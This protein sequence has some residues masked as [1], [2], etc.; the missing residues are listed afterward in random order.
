MNN[1]FIAF[2]KMHPPPQQNFTRQILP[3]LLR[4][5]M[6]YYSK[7]ILT[8][9][10]LAA[11]ATPVNA[12]A[13]K[14]TPAEDLVVAMTTLSGFAPDITDTLKLDMVLQVTQEDGSALGE[15]VFY[16]APDGT[17]TAMTIGADNV[18]SDADI[19]AGADARGELCREASAGEALAEMSSFSANMKFVYN[20]A[21]GSHMAASVIKGA[22]DGRAQLKALAPAAVRLMVPKLKYVVASKTDKAGPDI[23]VTAMRGDAA[24]G[25][26]K[27][28]YFQGMP[29][30]SVANLKKSKADRVLITGGAYELLAMPKPDKGDLSDTPQVPVDSKS[31]P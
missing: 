11:F 19:L 29:T 22:S 23:T 8:A 25:A 28:Q 5:S 18:M 12:L 9:T 6:T 21:G 24:A 2:M 26:F 27:L 7:P 3:A 30:F 17:E 14:C 15:R 31:A 16:R 4:Q 10:A 1:S 20:D 13:A